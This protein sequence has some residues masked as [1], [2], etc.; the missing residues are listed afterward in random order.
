MR[1]PKLLDVAVQDGRDPTDAKAEEVVG[2]EKVGGVLG[3]GEAEPR[4]RVEYDRR[5]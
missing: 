1:G 2:G 5:T 3:R 4:A